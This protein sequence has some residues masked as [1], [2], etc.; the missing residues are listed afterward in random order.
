MVALIAR[1]S[2]WLDWPCQVQDALSQRWE[3]E[4]TLAPVVAG[5][6][7]LPSALTAS[8][9]LQILADADPESRVL[10]MTHYAEQMSPTRF[11][12]CSRQ[13]QVGRTNVAGIWGG[14]TT[15]GTREAQSLAKLG[16]A[17]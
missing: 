9:L 15:F 4:W 12:R 8:K 2:P 14:S 7:A 16:I 10:F 3:S 13:R 5:L 1:K 17:T 11:A 6:A